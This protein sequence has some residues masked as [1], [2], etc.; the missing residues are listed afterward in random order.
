MSSGV[1]QTLDKD[2]KRIV[3]D[4]V[5]EPNA[6]RGS[7]GDIKIEVT[8]AEA[9]PQVKVALTSVPKEVAKLLFPLGFIESK[10]GVY[11]RFMPAKSTFQIKNVIQKVSEAV[12]IQ[13]KTNV[14]KPQEA[15][16]AG[17][18]E[19]I[20]TSTKE[21]NQGINDKSKVD[22]DVAKTSVVQAHMVNK[23]NEQP[24]KTTTN[25]QEGAASKENNKGLLD[26]SRIVEE[27]YGEGY[28]IE[29]AG[30]EY[31]YSSLDM[32]AQQIKDHV[33]KLMAKSHSKA[34]QW[35][36]ANTVNY[37]GGKDKRTL[38]QDQLASREATPVKGAAS[39]GGRAKLVGHVIKSSKKKEL[40][41]YTAKGGYA[42]FGFVEPGVEL[43]V[44]KARDDGYLVVNV[45][46]VAGIKQLQTKM[47]REV[48]WE[49]SNDDVKIEVS[50]Q[51]QAMPPAEK[52][53][54]KQSDPSFE[55]QLKRI[56]KFA[57][58]QVKELD[59]NPDWTFAYIDD[60]TEMA[61]FKMPVPGL[62]LFT[63][64]VNKPA[65]ELNAN[66]VVTKFNKSKSLKRFRNWFQTRY[67]GLPAQ[68][69]IYIDAE[70]ARSKAIKA[71]KESYED[72]SLYV[73][74]IIQ[75]NEQLYC[76]ELDETG[77]YIYNE[78]NFVKV[79]Y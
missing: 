66:P 23:D 49:P 56:E 67:K 25:K 44:V 3:R 34:L 61:E 75:I 14:A 65:T 70:A 62:I 28:S 55:S 21:N 41:S 1:I 15:P 42:T 17:S 60:P 35:L 50:Q 19:K 40:K 38:T 69:I 76:Y 57:D 68:A 36:K 16:K 79:S 51:G 78:D 32:S 64:F 8:H 43:E 48:L 58:T 37:Y 53:H 20:G 31:R 13:N 59:K 5:A 27:K 24:A 46:G 74:G 18:E 33:D 45:K 52:D 47:P 11:T 77:V 54:K 10:K 71:I 6:L 30:V 26:K 22:G 39:K 29:I 4:G 2:F 9:D 7:I 63:G 12:Q 73:D 72:A